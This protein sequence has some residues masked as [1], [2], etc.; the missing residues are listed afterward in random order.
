MSGVGSVGCQLAKNVFGAA[1][2]IT[3]VSTEKVSKVDE[4]LGKGIVDQSRCNRFQETGI[5]S[6]THS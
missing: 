5:V 3:T 2:V 6:L 1:K 4:L